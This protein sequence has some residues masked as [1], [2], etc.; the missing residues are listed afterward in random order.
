L[1]HPL[2]KRIGHEFD[3]EEVFNEWFDRFTELEKAD[4]WKGL[5]VAQKNWAR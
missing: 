1:N 4:V 3:S 5:N 2:Y